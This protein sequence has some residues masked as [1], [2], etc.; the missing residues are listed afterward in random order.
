MKYL[1]LFIARKFDEHLISS[2]RKVIKNS[3]SRIILPAILFMVMLSGTYM[4][5]TGQTTISQ[6]TYEPLLGA[7]ATPT[8]NT[9]LGTS[10]LIGSMSGPG[11]ATGMLLAGTGCGTQNGAN[12]GAWAISTAAPGSANETSGA[13]FNVSTSGYTGITVRWDQRWSNSSA[14]TVRLQ[15]TTDGTNWQNFTMTAGNTTL[16]GGAINNGRFETNAGDQYRRIIVDLS[17]ITGINNNSNFGFRVV[18]AHYQSTSQFRQASSTT[19]VA[20]GGTWRFDN[21]IVSGTAITSNPTVNLSVSTNSASETGAT[22]ITVTATSSAPVSGN[23][24]VSLGV[25]GTGITSGDY[26]L[27]NNI[28]TILNGTTA[29]SVSFTITDDTDIEATETAVL[30]LSNPSAGINLG[31]TVTQNIMITDNDAPPPGLMRITEYMYSGANGEFV[32]FTNVGSAPVDMTGWS[33]DDAD[34]T[35]GAQ[36]LT[37]FG[38][39]Q[40]GESVILTEAGASAFRSAWNLCNGIKIIG[41]LTNNLGREDEINLYNNANN[42]V[43]RITFGDQTFSPGSIRTQNRSGWVNLAGLGNNTITQWTLS[44]VADVEASFTSSGGDIGSP[45]KSTRATVAYDP[46]VTVIGPPTIV[47][48]VNTTTNYLDG[49]ATVSPIS[50]YAVSAVINDPTDPAKF[51][52]I[53]FTIADD[54]TPVASLVV[55]ALSSNTAVVPNTNIV[56]SGTAAS[57]NIKITPAAVG[58]ATITISV[59][60]G[61]FTTPYV[62]NYAASAASIN[63]ATTRFLTG[64][65]DASTAVMVDANFMFV[66]DDENQVLRLY[67]R[68]NSGLPINGFDY[69]V[70][71]GVVASNPEVDIESSVRIGNRIYWLGSHSNSASSGAL[72]PNRYRLFA[73]DISGSG[74]AATLSYVGRYDNLRTDLINWDV[75]NLHGL[76]ANYFGLSASAASG[77][78][79]EASSGAGFNIEGLTVAPDGTTAYIC[80]RAPISPVSNRTKALIVPLANLASFVTGNPTS[81]TATFGTPILLDLG[82]RGIREIKRNASGEYLIIAGPH[83]AATGIAPKDFRFYT[84]TGNAADAPV[85]RS[86]NLTALNS[87]GSFESIVDIPNPLL[88]TSQIQVL[89]DNGDAVFYANGVIAKDLPDN[90]HKKFRSELI[91]LGQA[92]TPLSATVV[93]TNLSACG[94]VNDGSITVT[95]AGGTAP[96]SYSWSGLTGPG[97]SVPFPNP[98]NVSA[99]TGLNYGYY[100]VTVTDAALHSVSISNIHIQ[101]AFSVYI[102]NSGSNSSSCGNTGSILLYGN[103]GVTPYTY[104]LDG[105]NYQVSNSFTGLAAGNYIGYIKDAAGCV[106]QKNITIGSAP[107][108]SVS[109]YVVNASNCVADG[110]IQVFRTG[111]IPPYTYSLDNVT[112][113]TSNLFTGIASGS[114][115]VYV[116]D[117]KDCIG[118]QPVTVGQGAAILLSTIKRNTSACVNDGAI[119]ANVIGGVAPYTYSLNGGVSQASNIFT[120][121]GVGNYIITV[122][123]SK[124]CIGTSDPV[125]IILNQIIPTAY[126]TAASTCESNNGSIQLFRSGGVGPYTYSLDG[127]TYQVSNVFSQLSPGTYKAYVKDSRTCIAQLDGIIVGPTGCIAPPFANYTKTA[128]QP[129]AKLVGLNAHAY[130]NPSNSDFTLLLEGFSATEKIII[131]VTDITGRLVYQSISTG[132]QQFKFGAG[133]SSGMYHVRIEQGMKKKSLNIIKK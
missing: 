123:D 115:T 36:S 128:Q 63:T 99:V 70:S 30:T 93:K 130:P 47:I 92:P 22:N 108:I 125:N 51:S 103:A 102:T 21:V 62:I 95:A 27:S 3:I 97:G 113:Q 57:R 67:N 2:S 104:S 59:S 88:S 75:N 38:I 73:T 25:S 129:G 23:Q 120:G 110:K 24:T 37:A 18:A 11:T 71:L 12:P 76:G 72:R 127:N 91:E 81:G 126:A 79:P 48:D 20:T 4:S 14:N 66:A 122:V 40:P 58:F 9:G 52:G 55:T 96:Y 31:S 68:Q 53:D 6:W 5:S 1:S 41:G 69:S 15:Y 28:I 89:A 13:Q 78:F 29:G 39:V 87:D 8:P 82:G 42:L 34:R 94:L 19:S 43:D 54:V 117:S 35:P 133:F 10:A 61:S 106:S 50:P 116:K 56:I 64:T 98:G 112:Y 131:T 124:G 121:L 83:D 105:I 60:D 16:C 118:S 85:I 119:Q 65:S 74:A 114:Y 45:G 80:F 17:S 86:G 32:E 49:A 77:I 84:W 46:C 90:N 26:N 107:A 132:K 111:G 109:T 100:N 101:L 44:S 7:T 33:F